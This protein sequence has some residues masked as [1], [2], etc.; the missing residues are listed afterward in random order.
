[1][2]DEQARGIEQVSTAVAE[3]DK[4]TQQNA[5]NA[6]ESASSSEEMYSQAEELKEMVV[7]LVSLV[8]GNRNQKTDKQ[9]TGGLKIKEESQ[10]KA[11]VSDLTAGKDNLAQRAKRKVKP[12]Q[13]K[14]MEDDEFIDF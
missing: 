1:M 6:E 5:A 8:G 13:F 7:K 9:R 12:E 10:R 11:M 2:S 14:S 4:V 3:M